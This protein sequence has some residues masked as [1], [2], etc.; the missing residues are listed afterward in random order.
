MRA[1]SASDL[2]AARSR[3]RQVERE[4]TALSYWYGFAFSE[5]AAMPNWA[6]TLY[7]RALPRLKAETQQ[8]AIEAAAFAKLKPEV[9]RSIMRRLERDVNHGIIRGTRPKSQAEMLEAAEAFGVGVKVI[10][11]DGEEVAA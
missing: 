10:G 2:H 9:Q 4:W 1:S 8:R 11:P 7:V 3:R 5:I 6:R